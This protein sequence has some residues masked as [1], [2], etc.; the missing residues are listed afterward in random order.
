MGKT[1]EFS[2]RDGSRTS[3]TLD[4]ATLTLIPSEVT[5]L[6]GWVNN[7]VTM[8]SQHLYPGVVSTNFGDIIIQMAEELDTSPSAV[9]RAAC[10]WWAGKA[11]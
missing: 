3:V 1:I 8:L 4:P 11:Y 9:V 10:A 7:S 5:N 2:K 6:R